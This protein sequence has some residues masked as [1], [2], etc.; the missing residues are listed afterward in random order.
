MSQTFAT[1]DGQLL[2]EVMEIDEVQAVDYS[3][4]EPP[5]EDHVQLT[6]RDPDGTKFRLRL[7]FENKTAIAL[8]RAIAKHGRTAEKD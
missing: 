4:P 7:D 5:V 8:G 2:V 3:K 6:I 1:R